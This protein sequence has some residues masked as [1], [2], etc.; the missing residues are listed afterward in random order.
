MKFA[1]IA[2]IWLVAAIAVGASG[3]LQRLA[4]PVPQVIIAGLTLA[5]LIAWRS[6]KAFN[7]WVQT[8]DLRALMA[9]HL[10][11]FVGIYFLYL[12]GRGEL[13]HS[14]AIP[15]GCGD[16]A[17]ATTTA[18]L[19]LCWS[20]LSRKKLW[21]GLWNA[22]GLLDIV[23]VVISA[24]GHGLADRTSMA[25][26]LHLPLS[27]LPTFL[28]PLIIASHIFIFSRLRKEQRL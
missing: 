27:L 5:L 1:V 24:A 12:S 21:V 3:A 2:A 23:G 18:V 26:L 6:N 13:P 14:F 8:I 19:L 16:I 11:R 4:P 17:V 25:A 9:V 28:V 7:T 22:A 20:R 15:A 10:T